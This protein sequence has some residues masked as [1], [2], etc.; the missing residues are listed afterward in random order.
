MTVKKVEQQEKKTIFNIIVFS[1]EGLRRYLIYKSVKSSLLAAEG[2]NVCSK[3]FLYMHLQ[4]V[5]TQQN[6]KWDCCDS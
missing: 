3:M 1:E 6:Y 2:S 5:R 4:V